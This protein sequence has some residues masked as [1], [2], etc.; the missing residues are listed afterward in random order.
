MTDGMIQRAR[1]LINESSRVVFLT[2]AGISTDAGIPDFRGPQGVWTKDPVA[3]KM[4]DIRYYMSDSEVRHRAWQSR[5]TH[6]ALRASPGDGHRAIAAFEQTGKVNCLIT[7]NIDGL[8]Q[9]AGS[10]DGV[11]IEIHGTIHRVIC[12]SCRRLTPMLQELERVRRGELDPECA[13]C[14]GI[15]KSDTISFG[16]S[17]DERKINAAFQSV[18]DCDLLIC[19]GTTL[20]VYPIAGVVDIAKKRQARVVIINN[21]ATPYDEVADIVI[22]DP[23]SK[24]VPLLLEG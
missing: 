13:E 21:Q 1:E 9:K 6:P 19:I 15:L 17:L 7:Q 18:S 5:L 23:I 22:R 24:S 20:Q 3:E 16:Q 8:H 4:S 2:G 14:G 10:S 11:V 12:M